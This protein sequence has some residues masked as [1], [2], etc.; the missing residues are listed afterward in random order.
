[1]GKALKIFGLILPVVGIIWGLFFTPTE[2]HMGEIYR[3]IY[4]H[5]PVCIAA[6]FLS[7]LLLIVSIMG[8]VRKST[9]A[10]QL[11]KATAEVG[12]LFT[13]LGLLTGSIW[14]RA[15]WGI[16]WTWDARLTT[17]LILGILYAGYLVLYH[18][19]S[20]E[21]KRIKACSVMGILIAV[22]VPIIY[23][24]VTW[25]RTIHQP[26]SI[27]REGGSTM[28]PEILYPL[29][30]TIVSMILLSSAMVLIRKSNLNLLHTLDE[31]SEEHLA[32]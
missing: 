23:K 24:S 26:P 10:M 6:F 32:A 7:F 28:A 4:I 22:D 8:L 27:I 16:W 31:F 13:V 21:D 19:F 29:V 2:Q 18:S 14:G 20:S 9:N 25:W 30:F 1:M 5:V 12:F 15:T 17:T 11:S 3:V